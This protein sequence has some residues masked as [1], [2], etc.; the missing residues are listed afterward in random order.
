LLRLRDHGQHVRTGI[1]DAVDQIR[2]RCSAS[3]F[4]SWYSIINPADARDRVPQRALGDVGIDA[5][6]ARQRPRGPAKVVQAPS[7]DAAGAN[8]PAESA[9]FQTARSSSSLGTRDRATAC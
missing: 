9:A 6:P 4:S 1:Q 3:A 2:G 5:G 8:G 7:G